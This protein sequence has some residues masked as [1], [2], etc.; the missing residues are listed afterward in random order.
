MQKVTLL[1]RK[2]MPTFFQKR[3]TIFYQK[4][5]KQIT[6]IE[7]KKSEL[8]KK[9]QIQKGARKLQAF[10]FFPFLPLKMK[11]CFEKS[12]NIKHVLIMNFL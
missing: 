12:E 7:T 9:A 5:K 6:K 3:L 8:K 1:Q 11:L 4:Q 10:K 2:Q